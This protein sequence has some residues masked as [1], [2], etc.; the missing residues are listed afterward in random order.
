M[1]SFTQPLTVTKILERQPEK[2]FLWLKWTPIKQYWIT[3]RDF[4][5][6]VDDGL[7]DLSGVDFHDPATFPAG[8]DIIFVPKGTKTDFASVP[9]P[10]WVIFP[11]DGIY[12]QAAVLHDFL[13]TTQPRPKY[14]ADFIFYQ[15]MGVLGVDDATRGIMYKAVD[16]FGHFAWNKKQKG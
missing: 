15:A 12:S 11:P 16:V 1:S 2:K 8:A 9:R 7:T 10:F 14:E 4:C 5:F 13:Y 3:D 6:V